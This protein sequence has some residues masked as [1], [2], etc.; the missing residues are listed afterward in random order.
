[1][2]TSVLSFSSVLV[3]RPTRKVVDIDAILAV[4][5]EV[6]FEPHAAARAREAGAHRGFWLAAMEYF[7]LET[8][9]LGLPTASCATCRAAVTY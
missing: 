7:T 8:R 3:Y 2:M 5:R 4:G 6:V 1:M 9:G